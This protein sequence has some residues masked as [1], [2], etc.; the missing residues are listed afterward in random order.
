MT[1]GLELID[2]TLGAGDNGHDGGDKINRNFAK[3]DNLL[4]GTRTAWQTLVADLQSGV[5]T[6]VTVNGDSTVAITSAPGAGPSTP[7]SDAKWPGRFLPAM[8]TQLTALGI[9]ARIE[10]YSWT[11]GAVG[12]QRALSFMAPW[13]VQPGANGERGVLFTSGATLKSRTISA[14]N[15]YARTVDDFEIEVKVNFASLTP[16][17]DGILVSDGFLGAT[18]GVALSQ[19]ASG[20]INLW[21]MAQG[22]AGNWA[23]SGSTTLPSWSVPASTHGIAAGVDTCIRVEFTASTGTAVMKTST[24]NGVTWTTVATSAAAGSTVV[25]K[26]SNTRSIGG[27]EN[28]T[29]GATTYFQNGTIYRA[30]IRDG[31]NGPLTVP[32]EIEEWITTNPSANSS[33]VGSPTLRWWNAAWTGQKFSYYATNL[34]AMIQPLGKGIILLCN[35]HNE[36][37]M[38]ADLTALADTWLSNVK[39]RTKGPNSFIVALQNPESVIGRAAAA[40]AHNSRNATMAAWARENGLGVMDCRPAFPVVNLANS[41]KVDGIHPADTLVGYGAQSNQFLRDAGFQPTV[42]F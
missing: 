23:V 29:N 10:L 8:G 20:E 21:Y 41:I 4:S 16:G 36:T 1:L 35:G 11:N 31:I 37:V 27:D 7:S 28:S 30:I 13:I 17:N 42:T 14:L 19:G 34:N 26:P 15:C 5:S 3:I 2:T 12:S 22:G 40:A 6:G 38:G 25:N 9:D 39:T 32:Y 33:L 24:N 18:K